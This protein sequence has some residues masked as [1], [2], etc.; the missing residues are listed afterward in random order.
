VVTA[1]HDPS[2]AEIVRAVIG[3]EIQLVL[4]DLMVSRIVAHTCLQ[5]GLS[6]V[7]EELLTNAGHEVYFE[8]EPR[9]E[10]L[11]FGEALYCYEQSTPI[12]IRAASGSVQICPPLETRI[13]EGDQVIA[14]SANERSL[15][16][17]LGQQVDVDRAGI[18]AAPPN[19][20]SPQRI[21][22]LGWN[23]R[24][25]LLLEHLDA[26]VAP[27]ST[28]MVVHGSIADAAA[29]RHVL[30]SLTNVAVSF[31]R[32]SDGQPR[33]VE[34]LVSIGFDRIIVLS[35]PDADAPLDA[36]ATTMAVAQQLRDSAWRSDRPFAIVA[37]TADHPGLRA[38]QWTSLDELLAIDR[39]VA[40]MVAQ[41]TVR[42]ERAAV[43][44]E[45]LDAEGAQ[46]AWGAAELYVTPGAAVSFYTVVEAA[47][48]RG[49]VALGYRERRAQ[50][51]EPARRIVV[52]PDKRN[53]VRFSEGDQILVLRHQR[54]SVDRE[55]SH[56]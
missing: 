51:L 10:G 17:S 31:E 47:R 24:A 45:L 33:L 19:A 1:L 56:E 44:H 37:E 50:T 28:L 53:A 32:I 36:A 14:I 38:R 8:L 30:Q 21:L 42:A 15:A 22:V 13:A 46:F 16:I 5:P 49:E 12:G 25:P 23:R 55:G 11:S 39:L 9:L 40:L 29:T 4:I 48:R 3:G 34:Q 26:L 18:Q 43:F 27:G 41:I 6:L 54:G 20:R 2:N 52:N 35:Q 7:F